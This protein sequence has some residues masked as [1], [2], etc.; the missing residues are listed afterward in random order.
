M[1][2][3]EYLN[4]P[5]K[6]S[7]CEGCFNK[8]CNLKIRETADKRTNDSITTITA[9][10]VGGTAY[11]AAATMH[12]LIYAGAAAFVAGTVAEA[13]TTS[14]APSIGKFH[15]NRLRRQTKCPQSSLI[16]KPANEKYGI[17]PK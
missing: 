5:E 7:K 15:E 4:E 12:D 17:E 9:A 6:L 3:I 10:V 14:C 8:G 2:T 1:T 11:V 13:I 16:F